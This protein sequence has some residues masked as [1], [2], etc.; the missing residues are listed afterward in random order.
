[1]DPSLPRP[2]TGRTFT[3]RR[4]VRLADMD[5]RGRLRLDAVAR[6]LQDVAIEDVSETGW[7]TPEHLWFVRRIRIEVHEPFLG[8][9]E[10]ELVTWCSGLAAIAAG[11]RWSV[12]GDAGGRLEVDSVW[13]HLGPDQRP[14]RIEGFGVYAEATG[15]RPVS[16]RLELPVPRDGAARSPWP[17]RSSDVDLH[18]HVNN[19]VYWQAVEDAIR[20]APVDPYGPLVAELDYRDPV[21]LADRIEL[22]AEEGAEG[23]AVAFCVGGSARAVARVSDRSGG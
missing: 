22:V 10:V 5:E 3:A 1:M 13:I 6:F 7:G 9:R 2:G 18:G 14:A 8:D 12:T 21:D 4:R 19:A 15:G 23:L 20:A 17:L 16:T 11:R